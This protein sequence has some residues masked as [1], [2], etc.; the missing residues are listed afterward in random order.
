MWSR[1]VLKERA[2]G[3][4][5][6]YYWQVFLVA[7]VL[8]FVGGT[9]AVG[10]FGGGGS[11]GGRSHSDGPVISNDL[12]TTVGSFLPM[13]DKFRYDGE[14]DLKDLEEL[15]F[16]PWF[17]GFA[18]LGTVL[19]IVAVSLVWRIFLGYPVEVGCRK[20]FVK[21]ISD[22]QAYNQMTF[23]FNNETYWNVVKTMFMRGLYNTLWYLLLII[24]G[25]IKAYAYSMVPYILADNPH[26]EYQE[27]IQL[28]KDMT[29]GHKFDMW[30][31]DLSFIGW[32]LLGLLLCGLGGVFVNP[33]YQS[34]R[35]ELY[36]VLRGIAVDKGICKPERL[37]LP[38]ENG[39]AFDF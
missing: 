22:E 25:V 10:P 7:L 9:T 38:N 15:P 39:P 27:A 24:P 32:Y 12:P 23:C 13:T 6:K 5:R 29:L 3:T 18:A 35:A 11:G 34:T 30:V 8:M 4:L 33:Y 1:T 14:W 20:F 31:L 26:M 16:L 2:K 28:S 21:A 37:N 17:I 19:F 36:L